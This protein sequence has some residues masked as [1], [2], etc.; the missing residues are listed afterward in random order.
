MAHSKNNPILEG[1]SGKIGNL[2]VKQYPNGKIVITKLPD[3]SSVKHSKLQS[4]Y[5][6]KFAEAVKYARAAKRD[7]L[8]RAAF[9]KV[10]K[11]GQDVYHAALSSFLQK[12]I[13]ESRQ[14]KVSTA[15]DT[16]STELPE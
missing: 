4:I 10:L 11:D 7:P 13:T 12:S 6:N 1:F 8:K 3:M 16:P 5:Q 9:E 2:V 15:A 14:M